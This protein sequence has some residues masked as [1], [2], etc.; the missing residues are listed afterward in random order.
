MVEKSWLRAEGNVALGHFDHQTQAYTYTACV[1]TSEQ[2]FG[3]IKT[4]ISLT[5]Y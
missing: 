2:S 4:E 1:T 5:L 3:S